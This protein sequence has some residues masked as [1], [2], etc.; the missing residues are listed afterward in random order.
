MD[1]SVQPILIDTDIGDDVDDAFALGFAALLPQ[2]QLCGVTTVGGPVVERARLAR[3]ILYAAGRQ[4]V[5]VVAGS[6]TMRNGHPGPAKFSHRRVLVDDQSNGQ[7]LDENATQFILRCS[8]QFAP[9]TI[10]ALGPLTNI[11]AALEADHTLARRA[12][13]VAMAGAFV[14]PYPDWNI[15]CDV[16]AARA[17]F[18]SGIP[19]TLIG[20]DL[21]ISTKLPLAQTKYL[22]QSQ[23]PLVQV[24]ARCVLA[25]RTWQ[26]RIP[27]L[28]DALAVAVAA[29]PE[30]V[31]SERREVRVFGLGFS[32][33]FRSPTPNA[34]VCTTV[35]YRRFNALLNT[36]LFGETQSLQAPCDFWCALASRIA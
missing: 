33:A 10:I 21:T 32:R 13:L 16:A 15:R 6:S 36:H 30:L 20:L 28:H 2:L 22:F 14:A 18:A 25:W 34:R 27:I 8:H 7:V 1:K 3:H 12:R 24:L 19:T 9:L 11:A 26:R 17:V 29:E 31:Q 4:N 23:R 5:P 35:D